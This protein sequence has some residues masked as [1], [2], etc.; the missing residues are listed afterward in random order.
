MVDKTLEY[1][2]PELSC[3]VVRVSRKLLRG[4][5]LQARRGVLKSRGQPCLYSPGDLWDSG[6]RDMLEVRL[7][8]LAC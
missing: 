4:R 6:V 3:Q 5:C 2:S 1:K 7:A 8:C